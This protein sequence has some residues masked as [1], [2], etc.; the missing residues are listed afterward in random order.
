MKLKTLRDRAFV[1]QRGRCYYCRARMWLVSPAEIGVGDS[2]SGPDQCTAEHLVARCDGGLDTCE[3]IV[4]ACRYCNQHRHRRK[5]ALAPEEYAVHVRK[6][7][8]RG[9][10]NVGFAIFQ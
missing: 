7:V 10:W 5:K 8:A 6:R 2:T 9:A 1:L 3:N 4:A